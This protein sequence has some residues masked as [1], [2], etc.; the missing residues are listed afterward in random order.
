MPLLDDEPV[1][2]VPY[3]DKSNMICG[4]QFVYGGTQGARV[5][6]LD[7]RNEESAIKTSKIPFVTDEGYKIYKNETYG[8]YTGIVAYS[9]LPQA[10]LVDSILSG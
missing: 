9:K 7:N 8:Q 3:M 1:F 6:V 5:F 2:L 4:T 10:M